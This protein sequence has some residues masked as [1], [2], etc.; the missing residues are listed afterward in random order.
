MSNIKHLSSLSVKN[1]RSL[2]ELEISQL[3]QVNLIVGQNNVG[4]SSLLEAILLWGTKKHFLTVRD[5]LYS[6]E[7]CHIDSPDRFLESPF[8]GINQ[9]FS[10]Y[11]TFEE[12]ID[13]PIIISQLKSNDAIKIQI[14]RLQQ[15]DQ[16]SRE[17][18]LDYGFNLGEM[19]QTSRNVGTSNT[20]EPF[21]FPISGT[22]SNIP[23]NV[24]SKHY[25]ENKCIYVS[26]NINKSVRI[27]LNILWEQTEINGAEL[28]VVR[29][30]NIVEENLEKIFFIGVNPRIPVCRVK[31]LN[32]PVPLYSM[33]DGVSRLFE[34]VLS[35]VNV[36]GGIC[37][38][39]ELENGLH[40]SAQEEIWKIIFEAAKNSNVQIF[41]TTH[42]KDVVGTFIEVARKNERE[43][44]QTDHFAGIIQMRKQ[45]NKITAQSIFGDEMR[46]ISQYNIEV[47]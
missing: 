19:A 4:K 9:L 10:Q 18:N 37:L 3:G 28:Q 21:I 17:L 31:G 8:L 6:R 27:P 29:V 35:V 38:I 25:L 13:K 34:I 32:C 42:S 39:D 43:N 23:I 16:V 26:P 11:P 33:G 5:I 24:Q 41:V 2:D 30:L 20:S 45:K 47:R 22:L 46:K 36:A 40:W 15:A 44:K 12:C 14:F 7:E 1:Y